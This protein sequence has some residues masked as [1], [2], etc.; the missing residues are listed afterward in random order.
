MDIVSLDIA[1]PPVLNGMSLG[2]TGF[3][4]LEIVFHSYKNL[5]TCCF[6]FIQDWR[7]SKRIIYKACWFVNLGLRGQPDELH[8][9]GTKD[10]PS[11]ATL[12]RPPSVPPFCAPM[13]CM[14]WRLG[15][16]GG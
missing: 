2:I 1:T 7:I 6:V 9:T 8:R 12:P 5:R 13:A 16:F 15:C 14:W 10:G 3:Q 11:N 4:T